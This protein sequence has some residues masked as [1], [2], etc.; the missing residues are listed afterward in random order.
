MAC[1]WW[2]SSR[3]GDGGARAA[4][5]VLLWNGGHV[6]AFGL[7]AGFFFLALVGTSRRGMWAALA[8]SCYGVL[9]ECHQASVPG[10]ACSVL[11]AVS[12]ASGAVLC[13]LSLS[14]LVH[15]RSDHGWLALL[16]V[17]LCFGSALA[18]TLSP[19]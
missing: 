7:L 15:A 5:A 13:V 2:L 9:D 19:W 4:W 1:L 3:P 14:W 17:P 8:A 12:D 10:R 18:A 6:V 11:D 16:F